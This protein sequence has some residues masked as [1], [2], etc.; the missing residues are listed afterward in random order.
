MAALNVVVA[1]CGKV[2]DAVVISG[3]KIG[4]GA[5]GTAMLDHVANNGRLMQ[6]AKDLLAFGGG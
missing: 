5:V 2:A 1:Y 6:F 3:A 4:G